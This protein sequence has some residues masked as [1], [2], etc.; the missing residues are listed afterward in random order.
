MYKLFVLK[1]LSDIFFFYILSVIP[2]P[3]VPYGNPLSHPPPTASVRIVP[4]PPTHSHFSILT[5][6][7]TQALSL[8]RNKGMSSH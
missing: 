7:Y 3:G 8:H 2:F 6:P 1:F 4:H 5:F